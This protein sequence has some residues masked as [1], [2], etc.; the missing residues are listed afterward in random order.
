ME[1]RTGSIFKDDVMPK[2]ERKIYAAWSTYYRPQQDQMT[3][4]SI[5]SHF[6]KGWSHH[7]P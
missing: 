5:Y 3:N 2:P 7:Q 6:E 1:A 4:A